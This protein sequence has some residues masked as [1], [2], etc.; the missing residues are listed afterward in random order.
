MLSV[1]IDTIVEFLE[2]TTV[3]F[4]VTA[5]H[6][7]LKAPMEL[8]FGANMKTIYD[9]FV[10]V[11]LLL[12]EL[13]V[14]LDMLEK[15]SSENFTLDVL[16]LDFSKMILGI[17]F[18]QN[19]FTILHGVYGISELVCE[20]IPVAELT[21]STTGSKLDFSTWWGA[22]ISFLKLIIDIISNVATGGISFLELATIS[23]IEVVFV[24]IVAYQRAL[25]IG[26]RLLLAPF[27]MADVA[28][29]GFN[30]NAM[31]YIKVFFALC[32]EGPVI[33]M[34]VVFI[35]DAYKGATGIPV[36]MKGLMTALVTIKLMFSAH[37]MA[38]EMFL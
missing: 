3:K 34:M 20:K 24:S 38:K 9:C 22:I 12:M 14:L 23:M 10:P 5:V 8:V 25:R 7:T 4:G 1:L 17:A 30:S 33:C 18:V 31:H 37:K 16:I 2:G 19:G 32:M 35:A 29:H 26:L 13:Y 28:G 11:A 6:N 15:V 27:V 36:F 21:F